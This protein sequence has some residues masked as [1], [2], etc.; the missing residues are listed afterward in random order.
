MLSALLCG[1]ASAQP[2]PDYVDVVQLPLPPDAWVWAGSPP[3]DA[4][5][6]YVMEGGGAIRLVDIAYPPGQSPVYTLR[7][8][9]FLM[10]TT[11]Q[12]RSVAFAPDF[13]LT[14]RFFVAAET[15]NPPGTAIREF[16]VSAG[17]SGVADPTPVRTVINF[18]GL[19]SDH[20]V[21]SIHFGR[22]GMLYIGVG[23]GMQSSNA[24]SVATLKGKMLR[25][26]VLSGIDDFPGDA[27]NNYHVPFG[28]PLAT[29]A[30]A[31]PEIWHIGLRN[32]WRWSF[33]RWTGD[34]WVCD[35]GGSRAGEVDRLAGPGT[36]YS[37][38]GWPAFDGTQA[39]SGPLNT[40]FTAADLVAPL[41][42]INREAGQC[43][44][45]GGVMY[46]GNAVRA[47]RGR[48]VWSDACGTDVYSAVF[49]GSALGPVQSHRDQLRD[50]VS[51]AA[52]GLAGVSMIAED[53][54]GELYILR[55]Q[56]GVQN[57]G[58]V[59]RVAAAGPRPLVADVGRA[60][61]AA[62]G[63]SV[64]DNNDFIAFITLFFTDDPRADVG[65]PGG[66]QG[67]DQRLD[68]NDFIAFIG[69]FFGGD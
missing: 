46:R 18:P 28:N 2:L 15:G 63:D 60:G 57:N 64:L 23:D 1:A 53:G 65:G 4:A 66:V 43:S 44:T 34:M 40:D 21:G 9:P 33:D 67:V 56:R 58:T 37:N 6:L 29:R 25:I 52:V 27:L 31:M 42:S 13:A 49:D 55:A 68:N 47:W 14:G 54:A 45:I 20:A 11:P 17:G 62:A 22:D 26:D 10:Q 51:G 24:Q 39:L 3:G 48:F 12:A 32:P 50:A 30:G 59:Y 8:A 36:P 61:G 38:F 69:A 41:L 35:V 7:A 19:T 5:H 16:V